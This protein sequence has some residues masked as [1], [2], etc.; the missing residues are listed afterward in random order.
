MELKDIAAALAFPDSVQ[1]TGFLKLLDVYLRSTLVEYEASF[2]KIY[3]E[4]ELLHEKVGDLRQEIDGLKEVH[5]APPA[6]SLPPPALPKLPMETAEDFEALETF[7]ADEKNFKQMVKHLM[8]FDGSTLEDKAKGMM[9][10]LFSLELAATYNYKKRSTGKLVFEG[11]ETERAVRREPQFDVGRLQHR[12]SAIMF[13]AF[14][15]MV[16]GVCL[17]AASLAGGISVSPNVVPAHQ[18]HDTVGPE[19]T[20]DGR[21]PALFL[22]PLRPSGFRSI[23]QAKN[24][25]KTPPQRHHGRNRDCVQDFS[26]A[27]GA[28][29]EFVVFATRAY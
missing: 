16:A 14:K 17:L 28:A 21:C 4:L 3:Q 10:G 12:S 24:T 29:C 23:Q 22:G 9:T 6:S 27:T 13:S 1:A 20:D 26:A 8:S 15:D 11:T 7:L 25:P 5:A 18:D 19:T 2:K